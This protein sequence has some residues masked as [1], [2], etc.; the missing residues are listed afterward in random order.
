MSSTE[1]SS[2]ADNAQ[3]HRHSPKRRHR[4]HYDDGERSRT[5]R[6]VYSRERD[7]TRHGHHSGKDSDHNDRKQRRIGGQ[8]TKPMLCY[9]L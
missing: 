1:T 5:N 6:L 2:G 8:R 7:Y 9:L 3:H 4:P